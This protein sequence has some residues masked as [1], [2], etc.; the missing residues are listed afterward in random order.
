MKLQMLSIVLVHSRYSPYSFSPPLIQS[1]CLDS[2]YTQL[3]TT[4][5]YYLPLTMRSGVRAL[6]QIG[7]DVCAHEVV[8]VEVLHCSSCVL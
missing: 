2:L 3:Q 1:S 7:W 5:K 8:Y 6:A 4:V